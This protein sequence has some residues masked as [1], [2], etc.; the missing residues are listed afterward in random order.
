[1]LSYTVSNRD[2]IQS[3]SS[4]VFKLRLHEHKQ[5]HYLKGSSR[6]CCSKRNPI[7]LECIHH[8]VYNNHVYISLVAHVPSVWYVC[9]HTCFTMMWCVCEQP[10]CCTALYCLALQRCEH[11]FVRNMQRATLALT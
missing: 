7:I 5:C 9:L 10:N 2:H 8:I 3:S 1:M 6:G 4:T 11:Q